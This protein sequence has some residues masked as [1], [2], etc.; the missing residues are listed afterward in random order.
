MSSFI[1]VVISQD[2][3]QLL[4]KVEKWITLK[5]KCHEI[6]IVLSESPLKVRTIAV[7]RFLISFPVPELLRFN[8]LK[9]YPKNWHE[10]CT[11]LDKNN[12]NW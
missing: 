11:V 3:L 2:E 6:F 4:G 7:Y 10:K 12:Q 8:D 5:S 1:Q 9:N